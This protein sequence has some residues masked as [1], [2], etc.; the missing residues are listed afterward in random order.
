MNRKLL[1]ASLLPVFLLAG[2]PENDA[3]F[4]LRGN[5]IVIDPSQ[6]VLLPAETYVGVTYPVSLTF[7]NNS[8]TTLNNVSFVATVPPAPEFTVTTDTCSTTRQL[9]PNA[10]CSY[11][12]SFTPE[13]ADTYNVRFKFSYDGIEPIIFDYTTN[14][15][16]IN[17]T[18]NTD[19]ALPPNVSVGVDHPLRVTFSNNGTRQ[20]TGLVFTSSSTN[21]FVTETRNTCSTLSTLNAGASCFI[22]ATANAPALGSFNY[23][24]TLTYDGGSSM[25]QGSTTAAQSVI[26]GSVTTA[27]PRHTA[28][29]QSY[30]VAF[31]FNN[32]STAVATGINF[33]RTY[34]PGF[35]ETANQCGTELGANSSCMVMGTFRPTSNTDAS[36]SLM[37]NYAQ[38]QS[39]DLTTAT[40]VTPANRFSVALTNV[41]TV[42]PARMFTFSDLAKDT[43][44]VGFEIQN[45]FLILP[46]LQSPAIAAGFLEQSIYNG[47]EQDSPVTVNLSNNQTLLLYLR[48]ERPACGRRLQINDRIL[49]QGGPERVVTVRMDPASYNALSVGVHGFDLTLSNR[50]FSGFTQLPEGGFAAM[51]NLRIV[52]TR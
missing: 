35:T 40:E 33:T 44:A 50:Y 1:M 42:T 18:N 34:P 16:S 17:I 5:S 7:R 49:C 51:A 21:N 13:R 25:A 26:T 37:M 38:G 29:N 11:A 10:S 2:C 6:S 30:P 31:T 19:V 43:S 12:G 8:Q 24:Y 3:N 9:A 36:V 22:E 23:T 14:T 4:P 47:P 20:A 32:V 41:N 45:Y 52:V 48:A 46:E 27:L 28:V 15:S 39:V